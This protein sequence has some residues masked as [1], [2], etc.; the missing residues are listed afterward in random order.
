MVRGDPVPNAKLVR[1]LHHRRDHADHGGAEAE[2]ERGEQYRTYARSQGG[3]Y[4]KYLA[5][6]DAFIAARIAAHLLRA[7]RRWYRGR[8]RGDAEQAMIGRAY[9]TH[10]LPGV[11]AG[12]RS[13]APQAPR[14]P[15]RQ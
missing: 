11:W 8:R 5:R 9:A 15:Q 13:A 6:G 4:G 10:L 7:L 12:L 14:L 3:F 1:A 2:S